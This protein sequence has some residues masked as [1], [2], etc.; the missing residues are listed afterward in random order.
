MVENIL[1]PIIY[2]IA[3]PNMI[4]SINDHENDMFF[5][6]Q[7]AP[8]GNLEGFSWLSPISIG[9]IPLVN[10]E[11]QRWNICSLEKKMNTVKGKILQ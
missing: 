3:I 11:P 4:K 9:I 10:F 8:T 7:N 6:Q 5:D 2:S 1:Y